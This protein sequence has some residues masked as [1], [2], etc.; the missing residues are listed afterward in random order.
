VKWYK[1]RSSDKSIPEQERSFAKILQSAIKVFVNS[2]Y[3]VAGSENFPLKCAPVAEATTA[4]G[5]YSINQTI[6]KAQS[7][8][9][10]VLYGD[11][12]SVFLLNPTKGQTKTLE[13]W[14]L[15]ELDLDLE[16]EKTYRFLA[17]S[18]RKKNYVG[19]YA[20]GKVDIKGMS[21][22][23]SN[24][25]AFI[26]R[27]FQEVTEILKKIS[28]KEEFKKEKKNII[29]VAR[30]YLKRI[31]KPVEKNGF[32]IEDYA[33]TI[34]LSRKLDAYNGEPQHVK[35]ARLIENKTHKKFIEGD[36]ITLV[37]TRDTDGAKPIYKDMRPDISD[38]NTDKYEENMQ[39]VFE[40]LLDALDITW[41]EIKGATRL[42]SFGI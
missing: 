6:E 24:T 7:L 22:K 26:T 21:A 11:T 3:G 38:I 30:S 36:Y 20:D 4:I 14:S 1:P 8:N 37:K 16:A 18:K 32:P 35:A 40:Q 23:K 5:R 10:S 41:G 28:N 39:K 17:L 15:K 25:P 29:K 42:D 13:E 2:A 33:V 27:A 12:D 9:I 31:G 34:R 19:I